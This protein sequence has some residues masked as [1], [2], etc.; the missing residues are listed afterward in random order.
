MTRIEG[1]SSR[2]VRRLVLT[3]GAASSK[4]FISAAHT[5]CTN[6]WVR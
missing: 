5:I 6:Q 2:P 3:G 1:V 4:G